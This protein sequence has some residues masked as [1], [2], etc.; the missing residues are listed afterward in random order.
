MQ[1]ILSN[2]AALIFIFAP[3]LLELAGKLMDLLGLQELANSIKSL[4]SKTDGSPDYLAYMFY[5]GT[6]TLI[7]LNRKSI[8]DFFKWVSNF[9]KENV[10]E[11]PVP[12]NKPRKEPSIAPEKSK[13]PSSTPDQDFNYYAALKETGVGA[14]YTRLR[15]LYRNG[16]S[17]HED[18]SDELEHLFEHEDNPPGDKADKWLSDVYHELNS[19]LPTEAF[20]FCPDENLYMEKYSEFGSYLEKLKA[21]IIGISDN[22]QNTI[23]IQSE[24]GSKH[25]VWLLDAIYYLASGEWGK[26]IELVS[27]DLEVAEPD[28]VERVKMAWESIPQLAYDSD[29]IIWGRIWDT[30][31]LTEISRGYWKKHHIDWFG[32][33]KGDSEGLKTEESERTKDPIYATLKT[34]KAIVEKI[35]GNR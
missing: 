25:D 28:I 18:L 26:I 20:K 29:L 10:Q 27:D 19:S 14:T 8:S 17:L 33:M 16:R 23:L 1:K 11:L 13:R 6:I 34:S 31:I 7:L 2:I 15:D 35:Y 24:I 22:N 9:P 5:I 3:K 32:I 30:G 12:D 4:L 21:I